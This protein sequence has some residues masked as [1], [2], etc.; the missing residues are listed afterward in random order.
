MTRRNG[1]WDWKGTGN[2]ISGNMREFKEM[3][4]ARGWLGLGI[5][6]AR[7]DGWWIHPILGRWV[8]V[9]PKGC[10]FRRSSIMILVIIKPTRITA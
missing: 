4:T 9:L 2:R 3:R 10:I 5:V 8:S 6:T 7:R 1:R